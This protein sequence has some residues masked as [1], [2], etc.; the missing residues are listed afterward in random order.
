MKVLIPAAGQGVRLKPHTLSR[1]KPMIYVAGKPII[2]HILDNLKGL[3]TDIVIIVGYMK[4]K[5]IRYVD[6]NYSKDFKI[7]YV[8]QTEMLGLGHAVYLGKD[9]VGSSP[10]LITLGDEFFGMSYQEMLVEHKK[11]MPAACTLGVKHVDNPSH[12]GVVEEDSG[13]VSRLIEKPQ[14][15]TTDLAIAGIYLIEDTGLLWECLE[16]VM[17]KCKSDRP[18]GDSVQVNYQL[19]D[20]LQLMVEK[21]AV[22]KTFMVPDWYDCGRA[23]MLLEVNRLLLDKYGSENSGVMRRCVLIDPVRVGE[24]CKLEDSIIGPHVSVADGTTIKNSIIKNTIIGSNTELQNMVLKASIINDEVIMHGRGQT[25]NVG[26][27][28]EIKMI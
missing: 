5:L 25:V 21:G 6:A 9:L 11:L 20:G 27:N 15:P 8:E 16:T 24:N 4:D 7:D 19:T 10:L 22:F 12:Y 2:G 28:S 18:N 23:E 14:S 13:K 1:P 17:G 26:E 3:F